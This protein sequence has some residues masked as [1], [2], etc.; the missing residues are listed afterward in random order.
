MDAGDVKDDGETRGKATNDGIALKKQ[1]PIK[2][3]VG[4]YPNFATRSVARQEMDQ[5]SAPIPVLM[6]I[7]MPNQASAR[8]GQRAIKTVK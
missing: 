8:N 4:K 2:Y 7:A 1:K 6:A 3:A 5:P